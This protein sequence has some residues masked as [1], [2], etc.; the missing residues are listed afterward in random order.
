MTKL[1]LLAEAFFEFF[2]LFGQQIVHL[3]L[4]L[5]HILQLLHVGIHI[6]VHIPYS[7]HLRY[8]FTLLGQQL[9]ILLDSSHMGCKNF[10]L[11][12]ED[13]GHLLLESKV[14]LTPV[15]VLE[16]RLYNIDV[17]FSLLLINAIHLGVHL[18]FHLLI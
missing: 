18:I 6:K 8:Q 2:N 15:V 5:H 12:L 13:V 10:F 3:Q 7:L 14:L 1:L 11:L 17:L 16:C 4:L 9:G